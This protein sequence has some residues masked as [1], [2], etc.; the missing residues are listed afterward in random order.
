MNNSKDISELDNHDARGTLHRVLLFVR[1]QL[2]ALLLS[3][4]RRVRL[5]VAIGICVILL[6]A[7]LD[8]LIDSVIHPDIRY[9]DQEHL[10][11]GGVTGLVTVVLFGLLSMYV[12]SLKRATK[13]IKTLEGLLPICS[14]CHKIRSSDDH[15][16]VLEKFI[17]AHTEAVFTHS[18]CPECARRL[19]PEMYET[20]SA[21][22]RPPAHP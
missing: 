20:S 2:N 13:A 22:R 14:S 17:S 19:Y 9:F 8:S 12:A 10:I 3:L 11:V 15:W 5:R 16:H 7:N 21:K 6:M 4:D 18:L 1:L